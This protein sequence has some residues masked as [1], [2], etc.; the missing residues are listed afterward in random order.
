MVHHYIVSDD[1]LQDKYGRCGG[2][3]AYGLF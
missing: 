2:G 1:I 3:D